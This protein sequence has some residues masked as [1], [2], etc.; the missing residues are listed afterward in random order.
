MRLGV[1][2]ELKNMRRFIDH[3]ERSVKSRDEDAV[4]KAYL[5]LKTMVYHMDEGD[6]REFSSAPWNVAG[7][8]RGLICD[9]CFKEFQEWFSKLTPEDHRRFRG[10]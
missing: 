3:M 7:D 2:R 4:Y 5:F 10:E 6:L 8:D 1:L 9:D